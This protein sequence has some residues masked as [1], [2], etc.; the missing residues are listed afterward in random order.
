MGMNAVKRLTEFHHLNTQTGP[1]HEAMM[2]ST[3]FHTSSS[4][5]RDDETG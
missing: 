1:A 3:S 2:D 5:A 4:T